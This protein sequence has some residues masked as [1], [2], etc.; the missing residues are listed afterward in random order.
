[1]FIPRSHRIQ[2]VCG[3]H[4]AGYDVLI[5]RGHFTLHCDGK[6]DHY[7]VPNHGPDIAELMD[8]P[9]ARVGWGCFP[10]GDEV[11]YLYDVDDGNF[12]YALN[13]SCGWCSKWGYAP[14]PSDR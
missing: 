8:R 2:I 1:V 5:T 13:L 10:D 4:I 11:I 3:S 7:E 6:T 14:F 9:G 12:G